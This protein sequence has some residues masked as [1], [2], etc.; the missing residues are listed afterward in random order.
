MTTQQQIVVPPAPPARP[1]TPAWEVYIYDDRAYVTF[2]G[3]LVATEKCD[4]ADRE[5]RLVATRDRLNHRNAGHGS[6][7]GTPTLLRR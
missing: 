4:T 5:A 7:P 6:V 3:R 1:Y 2:N